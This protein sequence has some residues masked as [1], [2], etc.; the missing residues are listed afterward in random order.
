MQQIQ[1]DISHGGFLSVSAELTRFLHLSCRSPRAK[2]RKGWMEFV[3]WPTFSSPIHQAR[4][5][6]KKEEKERHSWLHSHWA[7][8]Y[9][10][11]WLRSRTRQVSSMVMVWEQ[12]P[13]PK[14]FPQSGIIWKG[15]QSIHQLLCLLPG[16]GVPILSSAQSTCIP[17]LVLPVFCYIS[18]VGSWLC[19]ANSNSHLDFGIWGFWLTS[20]GP[21]SSSDAA[22]GNLIFTVLQQRFPFPTTLTL[23]FAFM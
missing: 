12:K 18:A 8:N 17:P 22:Q 6:G 20:D 14:C 19:H 4:K 2:P 5:D 15:F 16:M 9:K 11:N 10:G 23:N 1:Q 3:P 7:P 13:A 21:K